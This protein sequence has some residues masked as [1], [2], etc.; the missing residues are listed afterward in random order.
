LIKETN[1]D[2]LCHHGADVTD[3]KS[4]RFDVIAA[5]QNNA[6]NLVAVLEVLKTAGCHKLFLTGTVFEGGEGAGAQGLPD[7]SPYGFSKA[8]NTQVFQYYCGLLLVLR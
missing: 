4:A 6:R 2:L 8:L 5:L 1:W 3:Y 7:F